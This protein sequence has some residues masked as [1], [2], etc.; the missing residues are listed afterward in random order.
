MMAASGTV[1]GPTLKFTGWESGSVMGTPENP[2]R[3]DS[4]GTQGQF[5]RGRRRRVGDHGIHQ[6]GDE[7]PPAP[8]FH[9]HHRVFRWGIGEM[10]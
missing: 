4:L 5:R 7:L 3:M 9:I 2:H 1:A 6:K 10:Y 8:N